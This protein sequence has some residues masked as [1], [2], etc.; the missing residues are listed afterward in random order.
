MP[1]KTPTQASVNSGLICNQLFGRAKQQLKLPAYTNG[2]PDQACQETL[3]DDHACCEVQVRPSKLHKQFAHFLV[4]PLAQYYVLQART[5]S[6]PISALDH[7]PRRPSSLAQF[8]A[9]FC[10]LVEVHFCRVSRI[11]SRT[12]TSVW[13]S[14][15]HLLSNLRK[16]THPKLAGNGDRGGPAEATVHVDRKMNRFY[17]N[18]HTYYSAQNQMCGTDC[19][20]WTD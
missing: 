12:V 4:S 2:V 3:Q 18:A 15:C 13:Q 10:N 7:F 1:V 14:L 16:L 8:A 11:A 9:T 19:H 6:T 17:V 20:S 5:K